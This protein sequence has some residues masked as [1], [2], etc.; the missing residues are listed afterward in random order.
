MLLLPVVTA[1]SN[2]VTTGSIFIS[3]TTSG[4]LPGCYTVIPRLSDILG[5]R[6]KYRIYEIVG[7]MKPTLSDSVTC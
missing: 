5:R 2:F 1:V 7:Y 3:V 4:S 6:E